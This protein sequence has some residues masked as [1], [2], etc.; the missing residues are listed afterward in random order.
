MSVPVLATELSTMAAFRVEHT[1]PPCAV[2]PVTTC[3]THAAL[4]KGAPLPPPAGNTCAVTVK[5]RRRANNQ[6]QPNRGNIKGFSSRLVC[7]VIGHPE[8]RWGGKADELH[9][10]NG[11]DTTNGKTLAGQEIGAAGRGG[12]PGCAVHDGGRLHLNHRHDGDTSRL[13]V[14]GRGQSTRGATDRQGFFIQRFQASGQATVC[15]AEYGQRPE[16]EKERK[17]EPAAHNNVSMTQGRA[18]RDAGR[19]GALLR[20][21][22]KK[23]W[24]GSDVAPIP[25]IL[26]V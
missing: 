19:G 10:F 5:G 24:V 18:V 13:L 11:G 9:C 8:H 6:K 16:E 4:V 22:T 12:N 17:Q 23:A 1:T 25:R 20:R 15:M 14:F 2:I 21:D 3:C 7:F 26:I